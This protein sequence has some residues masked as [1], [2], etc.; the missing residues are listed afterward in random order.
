MKTNQ[1]NSQ[2]L[3]VLMGKIFNVLFAIAGA[4]FCI[5]GIYLQVINNL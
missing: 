3:P 1:K 4:I 2:N 5:Y